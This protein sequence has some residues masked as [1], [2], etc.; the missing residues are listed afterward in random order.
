MIPEG[1]KY[2]KEHEWVRIEGGEAVF[3]ITDHAQEELGDIT[4]VEMPAVGSD[5]KQSQNMLTI[6]SVK[7]ASEVYAPLSGKV[8]EVNEALE[9][10]PETINQSPYETGWL[11]RI[12]VADVGEQAVLMD[13][14]AY[15]KYLEEAEK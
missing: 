1:L 6:E 4:F 9:T 11:C 10:A 7:A 14:A 8:T 5:V 13:A 12:S 2:T 15:G 3:G